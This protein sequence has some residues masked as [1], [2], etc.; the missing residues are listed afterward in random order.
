[1]KITNGLAGIEV[2]ELPTE[3]PVGPV[4][5]FLIQ[6]EK[7]TLVDC[8]RKLESAWKIFKSELQQ[9]GLTIYDID[10]VI[11]T[12][13][14]TD[15]TGFLDW[16]L[17]EKEVPVYAHPNCKPFL[18]KDEAHLS[19]SKQFFAGFYQ[20]FG[21]PSDLSQKM[22]STKGWDRG[23][24]NAVDISVEIDEGISIP[25]MPDWQVIETKGHAQ[26]HISLYRPSDQVFLCG[27][28]II[29]H[30]P[31]GIFLEPPVTPGT[32]RAKPLI[33]YIDNL[34]KCLNMQISITL[35]GHG[36]PI[37]NVHEHI[38]ETLA[39]IDKRALRVKNLLFDGR[40][41]GYELVKT[42]YPGRDD[43]SLNVLASDTVG[44]LDLLLYRS[45]ITC[46][47][48]NGVLYYSI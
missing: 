20:E 45:E 32:K 15:H 34:K 9:R 8:G 6:G 40:K 17:E 16:L 22:L 2:I 23:L 24:K 14:H 39:K 31:A 33:Q 46:E 37:E 1:M 42:L 4:N 13:H 3:W 43:R 18:S 35:S 12:H 48:E 19:W 44:L 7:L 25:G 36:E 38:K 10:Q 5:V 30:T 47:E 21:I 27:D 41:N 29:K 28:H 26:S 11:L